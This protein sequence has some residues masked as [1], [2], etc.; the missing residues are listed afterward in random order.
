MCNALDT[1]SG[2]QRVIVELQAFLRKLFRLSLG[3]MASG[4]TRL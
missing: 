4:E 1:Y 3:I 2:C